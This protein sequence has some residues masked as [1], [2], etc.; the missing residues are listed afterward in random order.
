MQKGKADSISIISSLPED[1][2]L[3]IASLLQ[4]RIWLETLLQLYCDHEFQFTLHRKSLIFYLP[5][6]VV[7]NLVQ[8]RCGICVP[9]VV[10]RCSGRNSAS[11]IA[12]GSLLSE[13]D[14]PHSLP[15]ISLLLLPLI[16]PVSRYP[17]I[18]L[19]WRNALFVFQP[20]L[21]KVWYFSNWNSG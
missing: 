13:T 9:Q 6:C 4:V 19:F 5:F 16:L 7:F 11:Q 17:L 3:K 10:V 2:A 21:N 18:L 20:C 15:S 1:V 14:G 8:K 12:F